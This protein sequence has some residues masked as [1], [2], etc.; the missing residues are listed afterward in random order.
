M[1]LTGLWPMIQAA[2]E[3]DRRGRMMRR[4]PELDRQADWRFADE[5][6][7]SAE[8]QRE[9]QR[10]VEDRQ[11]NNAHAD[12]QRGAQQTAWA[13]GQE[14]RAKKQAKEQGMLDL[15][16][17]AM[18]AP[19]LPAVPAQPAVMTEN[20]DSPAMVSTPAAGAGGGTLMLP[21]VPFKVERPATAAQP[22]R[23]GRFA[24]IG[25][26][27]QREIL[28]AARTAGIGAADAAD[29][30]NATVMAST[31]QLP[32]LPVQSILDPATGERL[33]TQVGKELWRDQV[34]PLWGTDENGRQIQIGVISNGRAQPFNRAQLGALGGDPRKKIKVTERDKDTG[35][36]VTREVFEDEYEAEQEALADAAARQQWYDDSAQYAPEVKNL[37]KLKTEAQNNPNDSPGFDWFGA[38]AVP[39]TERLK[40]ARELFQ[41]SKNFTPEQR[42]YILERLFPQFGGANLS[43]GG[44]PQSFATPPQKAQ[45]IYAWALKNPNDPKAATVLQIMRENGMVPPNHGQAA[46]NS[47]PAAPD[48]LSVA[49]ILRYGAQKIISPETIIPDVKNFGSGVGHMAKDAVSDAA[50]YLIGDGLS[51]ED[52][53]L[54]RGVWG[55]IKTLGG[56]AKNMSK[57][58]LGVT[59][60][61]DQY[62]N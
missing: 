21:Q 40:Q 62:G 24:D 22:E 53:E 19:P 4:Q 61:Q 2:Q 39:N 34:Q 3:V 10:V 43:V 45:E 14:E 17:A 35:R 44:S 38:T 9:E 49:D 60:T 12:W 15:D 47:K 58:I 23:A 42:Q 28:A 25:G 59:S 8:R 6:A 31:G 37:I 11:R 32:P 18:L 1:S 46:P 7:R 16:L 26:D 30:Y 48:D 27:R 52:Q 50:D 33:G 13:Q 54:V 29:R 57:N 5:Q 41:T 36:S 20:R 56:R 51:P 55:K